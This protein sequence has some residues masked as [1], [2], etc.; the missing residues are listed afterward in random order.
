M[1]S[2]VVPGVAVTMARSR[3]SKRLKRDDLPAFG[4]PTMASVEA[5]NGRCGRVAKGGGEGLKRMLDGAARAVRISRSGRTS[6]S[7]SAKSMPASRAA[8]RCRSACLMGARRR[9]RAPPKLLG[10]EARLVQGGGVDEVADGFG[11]GE[12]EAAVEERALGELAGAGQAGAIGEGVG[13]QEVEHDGGA[14]GGDFEDVLA[15]VGGGC[16]EEGDYGV[17][18]GGAGFGVLDVGEMGVAGLEGRVKGEDGGEERAGRTGRRGARCRYRRVREGSRWRR[19]CRLR[20]GLGAW[21]WIGCHGVSMGGWVCTFRRTRSSSYGG[22]RGITT[23][24]GLA[25]A[26]RCMRRS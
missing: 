11:L 10:G 1:R 2:R 4:G 21:L 14:V 7:S 12:V 19:S 9:E 23:G 17:V 24:S 26:R 20:R 8:M 6:M 25:R 3:S 5:G 15:G 18:D 16:G 22:W 13:E